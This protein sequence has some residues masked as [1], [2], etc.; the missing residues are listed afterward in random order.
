VIGRRALPAS[1]VEWNERW[2]APFGTP[3][4]DGVLLHRRQSEPD[5]AYGPFAFQLFSGTRVF[6]YPWAYF[7]AAAGPGCRVL[8]VG[9]GMSGLQFVFAS[10]GCR[11]VNV[12]PCETES[13]GWPTTR[14]QLPPGL[15]DRLNALFGT[16]VTLVERRL[17]DAGLD[18][19]SFD[20]A[21]C[22]SVIEHLD[23]A[24]G[25]DLLETMVRLLVPGGLLVATIDL[26]LDLKPFGVLDRNKYGT[27]VD[28]YRLLDGLD[29]D[30]VAGDPRELY[31][32]PSFDRDRVVRLL[33]E[34]LLSPDYPC[35]S[36]AVVLRRRPAR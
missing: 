5:A 6:E 20:R 2:G 1:Q 8:D 26:F 22:L 19:G 23:P 18:E 25:R 3:A 4:A 32:F 30:L 33:P 29:T 34:L 28:V 9:G 17:Q 14:W 7:A 11:V 10:E 27:N 24:D 35:L 16:D 15:H 21:V 12:D 13:G 36:Q 31:G